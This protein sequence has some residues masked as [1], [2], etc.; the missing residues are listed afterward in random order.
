[1]VD[2]PPATVAQAL[3]QAQAQG[4]QRLDA[5]LLL[6]QV[7][8]RPGHDR[9]WLLTHDTQSLTA[10]QLAS[11]S[12]SAQ[13][14]LNDEP[15]AYITG[16]QEFFGLDLCVDNRVLIPRPDTE[17]LVQWAL[18][19]LAQ[20][21]TGTEPLRALDLG[22]GSG[23]IALALKTTRPDLRVNALDASSDALALASENARRLQLDVA[24]Q[25][26]CWL[27]GVADSFDVIVS[28]PP[29]I[30]AHDSH[31]KALR[32][33]PLQ[34]LTSGTDGLA[35]L[36]CIITQAP[37]HLRSGSWLLLEHGY[38]QAQAVRELL[39]QAGFEAVQ[40]RHDLGGIERCS[41]GRWVPTNATQR[42][43]DAA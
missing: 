25:Q 5:Q 3:R 18:D 4:L 6:L 28:N 37:A 16:H 26:G 34:A 29:Y 36:R 40:S 41:G 9:A 17:T 11:F 27:G 10:D 33:E 19:V 32:H 31:L 30:A 15:L 22:T 12:V 23:A 1:M 21:T 2:V 8:G 13:R 42:M 38:D 14:R 43:T 35:D 39:R 7:L 20:M 24:F